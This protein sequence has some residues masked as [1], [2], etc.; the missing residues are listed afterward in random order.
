MKAILNG[1]I[2]TEE[3][4][5]ENGILLFDENIIEIDAKGIDLTRLEPDGVFDAEGR[6]VMPG[7]VDLHIHGYMGNDVCDADFDSIEAIAKGIAENGVTAWCPTTMSVK[8]EG[9][10]DALNVIRKLK[11]HGEGAR[12]LGANVEGPFINPLK[13]GAQAEQN[14]LAPNSGFALDNS[15]IIKFITIAPEMK[16]AMEFIK[17]VTD[18][19]DIVTALGHTY[20][21]YET[22]VRAMDNGAFHITLL[23]NAMTPFNQRESGIIGA[24]LENDNVSCELIAD[25]FH[26]STAMY[27]MLARTKRDKLILIT[28]CMRAGGM[29]DGEYE[30][31]GQTVTVSGIE[32]KLAD[33]TIAGSVLTLNNAVYNFSKYIGIPIYEVVKMASLYPARVAGEGDTIGSI[34]CGKRAD[35]IIADDEM[36]IEKTF[37]GGRLI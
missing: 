14:I 6:Y 15:D 33:N 30:L 18:N 28:D 19:S 17:T 25:T 31:G 13:K 34:A 1:R 4:V 5:T 21:D 35:I 29:P 22:A 10:C 11:E 20:C 3:G 26:V 9:I 36:N 2:V 7:L 12:V 16:G 24:A 32:C 8:M 27:K 37:I 23:F